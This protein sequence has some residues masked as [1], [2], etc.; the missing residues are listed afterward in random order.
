MADITHL[1]ESAGDFSQKIGRQIRSLIII[2]SEN[3]FD[4]QTGKPSPEFLE[5]T[6]AEIESKL[7]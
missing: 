3:D 7:K 6:K 5:R 1:R 2:F 4:Y